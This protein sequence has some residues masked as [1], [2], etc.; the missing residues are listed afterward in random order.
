MPILPFVPKET[1]PVPVEAQ[2][3]LMDVRRS[4]PN[5]PGHFAIVLQP[6]DADGNWDESYRVQKLIARNN[7]GAEDPNAASIADDIRAA[8]LGA[9]VLSSEAVSRLEALTGLTL[10]GM[11]YQ[12][13]GE[14]LMGVLGQQGLLEVQQG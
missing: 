13:F 10:V 1:A 5:D 14:T 6:V 9:Q 3:K 8:L 11:S 4:T 12:E 2:M 7:R